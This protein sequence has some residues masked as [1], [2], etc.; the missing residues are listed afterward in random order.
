[1]LAARKTGLAIYRRDLSAVKGAGRAIIISSSKAELRDQNE[2]REGIGRFSK[3]LG[4]TRMQKEIDPSLDIETPMV[5][6]ERFNNEG[7]VGWVLY[8]NGYKD[9]SDDIAALLKVFEGVCRRN[10]DAE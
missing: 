8:P 1:M 7:Y 9:L 2:V 3:L 6:L 4:E 5:L 10:A